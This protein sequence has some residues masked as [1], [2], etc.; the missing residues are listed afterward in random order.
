[1]SARPTRLLGTEYGWGEEGS[2][3]RRAALYLLPTV[4]VN[5]F[6]SRLVTRTTAI[7]PALPFYNVYS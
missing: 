3:K 2:C 7:A 4:R 6:F 1:M 5:A